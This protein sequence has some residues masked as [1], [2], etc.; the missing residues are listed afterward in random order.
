MRGLPP[1][2]TAKKKRR[3]HSNHLAIQRRSQ[4]ATAR[5]KPQKNA[6]VLLI[7]CAQNATQKNQLAD[8]I[9]VVIDG[10]QRLTENRLPI[11]VRNF[12][13][14]IDSLIIYQIAKRFAIRPKCSSA[15]LPS[16]RVRRLRRFRPIAT[17]ELGRFVF[18]VARELEYVP[19]RDTEML[20]HFPWRMS[21][22]LR[23][24]ALQLGRHI[25]DGRF[26]IRVRFTIGQ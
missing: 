7:P 1:C 9:S 24:L 19:L 16:L 10:E 21:G 17:R 20:E 3:H 11:A 23:P 25:F 5:L 8:M 4:L 2:R 15:F 6:T 14:E 22:T 26:K 12:R 18:A 13:K